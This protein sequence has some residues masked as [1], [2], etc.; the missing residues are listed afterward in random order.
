MPNDRQAEI[1]AFMAEYQR[2]HTVPPSTRVIQRHFGFGSQ[3]SV[4]RHLKSLAEKKEIER[5]SD[6]SWGV[7]SRE[8]ATRLF[9][10]AVYGTIPAGLP[11]MQD[12]A[13][14]QTV[15]VDPALFGLRRP[16]RHQVWGLEISG[17]S[18]I[19]AHL[20]SGDIGIFERREPRVGE[21]VAALVDG[22]TTLKRLVKIGE[23][24]VLRAENP[25]Y[26]DIV[27][28]EQLEAQG[29]LV[30]VLRKINP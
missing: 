27:P 16:R 8:S 10:L 7:S 29:V 2:D 22:G 18:M 17:D 19:G 3:T 24:L 11:A 14:L 5:L 1:L 25:R 28:A 12:Q 26:P 15:G 6:G 4:V 13:P 9:E 20:C 30:G 21:I 23:R